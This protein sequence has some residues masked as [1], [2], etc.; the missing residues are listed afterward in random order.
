MALVALF[1]WATLR[2]AFH[3]SLLIDAGTAPAENILRSLLLL[4]LAIGFLLWGIRVGRRDWRLASLVLMLAAAGK[5]FLFDASGLEGLLRIG[6]FVRSEEHTSE[7]QSLMRISY[8]V[9][10]LKKKK[11]HINITNNLELVKE[12]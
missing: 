12:K 6:S 11:T 9:F 5:V 8:A 2:H 10:C 4:L 7:L 1:A 3:G